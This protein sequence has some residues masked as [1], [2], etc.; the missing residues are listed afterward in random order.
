MDRNS[1]QVLVLLGLLGTIGVAD[2]QTRTAAGAGQKRV[3]EPNR[4]RPKVQGLDCR[5]YE[6]DPRPWVHAYCAEVDF[7]IQDMQSRLY[8][9]PGPSRTVLSIPAL[10]TAEAKAAG[11]YC[12]D[13]RVLRKEGNAWIQ[14]LDAERNY[15]RCRPSVELPAISIG[16]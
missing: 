10:G 14:A 7:S 16:Q 9:Y 2:A 12:A 1:L 8:G 4:I 3:A 5:A 15:L 13:G 11:V 6:A